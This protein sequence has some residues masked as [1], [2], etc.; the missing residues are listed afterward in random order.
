[1]S[2]SKSKCCK[3]NGC[4]IICRNNKLHCTKIVAFGPLWLSGHCWTSSPVLS[5]PKCGCSIHWLYA[6]SSLSW[7]GS[8]QALPSKSLSKRLVQTA[9][10]DA[11]FEFTGSS[12]SY[13]CLDVAGTPANG[14]PRQLHTTQIHLPA[15]STDFVLDTS[16]EL[17]TGALPA[18]PAMLKNFLPELTPLAIHLAMCW[19][20]NLPLSASM[21]DAWNIVQIMRIGNPVFGDVQSVE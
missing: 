5:F 20:D 16:W 9:K 14:R 6:D 17:L 11:V 2:N 3:Q 1:M 13:S 7:R 21:A 19:V 12:S 10:R 15:T 18:Q 4:G 8:R